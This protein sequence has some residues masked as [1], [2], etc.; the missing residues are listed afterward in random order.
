MS[1]FTFDYRPRS[2][3]RRHSQYQEFHAYKTFLSQQLQTT[4]CVCECECA[5]ECVCVCECECACVCVCV[6]VCVCEM[7]EKKR[8]LIA[9]KFLAI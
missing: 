6:C 8:K 2:Q 7:F 3:L 9:F 5:C 1:R 4:V